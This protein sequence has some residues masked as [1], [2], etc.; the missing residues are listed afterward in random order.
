M[1]LKA[2]AKLQITFE[3]DMVAEND[4]EAEARL[5]QL[6]QEEKLS[7]MLE[8]GKDHT[9]YDDPIIMFRM[10]KNNGID[11]SEEKTPQTCEDMGCDEFDKFEPYIEEPASSYLDFG[12]EKPFEEVAEDP[13]ME[14]YYWTQVEGESGSLWLLPGLHH[15]NRLAVHKTRKPWKEGQEEL[16]YWD[17]K[18]M[19]SC[20]SD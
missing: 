19:D 2:I 13:L 5:K 10:N 3:F 18:D 17:Q 4:I 7:F 8:H 16:L 6:I 15:I 14:N 11:L 12:Y 20:S 1:K 9:K